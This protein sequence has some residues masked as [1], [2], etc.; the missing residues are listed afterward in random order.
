MIWIKPGKGVLV[1]LES[2]DQYST[3]TFEV[4]EPREVLEEEIAVSMDSA[5]EFLKERGI[6][7]IR[8]WDNAKTTFGLFLA[9]GEP[10]YQKF[11]FLPSESLNEFIEDL[12]V[13]KKTTWTDLKSQLMD[14][15]MKEVILTCE[16]ILSGTDLKSL[17]AT[18]VFSAVWE[19]DC[20]KYVNMI[21]VIYYHFQFRQHLWMNKQFE[22]TPELYQHCREKIQTFSESD[23]TILFNALPYVNPI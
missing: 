7:R 10:Y 3:A 13:M 9:R 14:D 17:Y 22:K 6:E 5:L 1:Y 20:D 4:L 12:L 19:A 16:T 21:H 18:D 11:G 8:V 23:Q 2:R 15:R